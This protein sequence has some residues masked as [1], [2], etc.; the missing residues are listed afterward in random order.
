ME[1]AE[2][3]PAMLSADGAPASE[4]SP[5]SGE[6]RNIF[7][8]PPGELKMRAV[9]KA[10]GVGQGT[11][12]DYFPTPE[13]LLEALEMRSWNRLLERLQKTLLELSGQ[14]ME[15]IVRTLTEIAM[16]DMVVP[17]R[18]FGLRPDPHYWISRRKSVL[19]GFVGFLKGRLEARGEKLASED[20]EMALTVAMYAVGLLIAFGTR[21]YPDDYASGRYTKEVS[22]MITRFL[23]L[24][25]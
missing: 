3:S 1:S 11:L 24:R 12:Y 19:R 21:Y 15:L 9:A 6:R 23:L 5:E 20:A 2:G 8:G 17:A 25:G 7:N 10:A 22:S 4:T 14:D 18:L 13:A 16:R